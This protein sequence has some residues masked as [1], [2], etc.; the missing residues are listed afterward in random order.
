MALCLGLPGWASTTKVKPIWIL[1]KQETVSGKGIGWATCKSA[2]RSRQITTPAP[3]HSLFYRPGALPAAQQTA[4]NHWRNNNNNTLLRAI[5]T[6]KI[7][8][9]A[10]QWEILSMIIISVWIQVIHRPCFINV[11]HC[12]TNYC[13]C[14]LKDL[15]VFYHKNY[16]LMV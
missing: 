6:M 9:L 16:W 14:G 4:W 10:T 15:S 5:L 1:L 13:Y 8:V 11:T 3:H 12:I 7:T 2:P